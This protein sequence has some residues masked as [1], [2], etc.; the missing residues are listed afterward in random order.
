MNPLFFKR[1]LSI[2]VV[3]YAMTTIDLFAQNTF[4]VAPDG[5]DEN[6][7]TL[8][9]PFATI[10][11]ARD[12]VRECKDNDEDI[13]VFL[14]GGTYHL[15]KTLL[16]D[17]R[18]SGRNGHC[19]ICKAYK[20]EQPV[21]SGGRL[22]GDW[23][24][25]GDCLY[26]ATVHS[27][28]RQLYVNNKR[29]VRAR[30][31]N[32]DDYYRLTLWDEKD[33]QI[34]VNKNMVHSWNNFQD[35]EMIVHMHW[36]EAIL[37]LEAYETS[38]SY[39]YIS[40]Q[41]PE[42]DLV[43][44][45]MYPIKSEGESFHFENA[46]EFLD[47]PGEWYHDKKTATLY[48]YP[49]SDE[50]MSLA[51][52]VVPELQTLVSIQGTFDKPVSHL[53]FQGITFKH[54]G[55]NLPGETGM[56]NSQA[57][58]YTVRVEQ[59]NV[60]YFIRPPAAVYVAAA[61]HL[62]FERNVFTQCGSTALDFHFGTFDNLIQGNIFYELSGGGIMYAKFSG[63]DVPHTHVYNPVDK[64]EICRNDTIRNNV[65]T[66]IGLD[67]PG[68]C[69]IAC[70]FPQSIVIEHNELF[71]MPYTGISV[72]WSWVDAENVMRDNQ[73]RYNHIFNVL[74]LLC[75]GG[76]I[77]TLSRQPNSV[78]KE[79]YIHNIYRLQWAVGSRN[80]GIFLDQ[81]SSGITLERNVF[82]SIQ[83]ENIR[84]NMTGTIHYIENETH[85][86]KIIKKSGLTKEYS[87]L[88][89]ALKNN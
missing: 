31:P 28:F 46:L 61:H 45:R 4:Y 55:W 21:I 7:G 8:D 25:F 48:Y 79:N 26:Q 80:N 1:S 73:I 11:K 54:S 9:K 32:I 13:L 76:G 17:H 52:V 22:I 5:R 44:R 23:K 38:E 36:A 72:G 59:N 64:R 6:P 71:D 67:Y 81:G 12:R 63:P 75:D 40:V 65:V 29:A 68:C 58:H 60:Q 10:E 66:K 49:R 30:T 88:M 2:V 78:I 20:D 18:D 43:F 15:Q 69:G 74:Q 85:D 50:D 33:R 16:F 82:Q 57:G 14:R 24:P 83:Q 86:P 3:F 41:E 56:L 70:G 35:V 87:D 62:N 37:P 53:V 77:Y 19:V 89:K 47:Q 39:A 51:K 34:I 27:D 42:R 84:H